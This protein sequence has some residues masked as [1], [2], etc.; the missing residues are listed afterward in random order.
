MGINHVILSDMAL[1][2]PVS[3]THLPPTGNWQMK[4]STYARM[5]QKMSEDVNR[6]RLI[7][8]DVC[9]ALKE[10]QTPI[11]VSYTHLVNCTAT[12]SFWVE[13]AVSSV[14]HE[15]IAPA[16]SARAKN[17]VIFFILSIF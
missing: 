1:S 4:K 16:K 8:D 10:G 6:N 14:L 17:F 3:Y 11:A 12:L 15:T 5:V 7:T 13:G 2:N 9:E